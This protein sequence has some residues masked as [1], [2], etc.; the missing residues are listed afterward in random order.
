MFGLDGDFESGLRGEF[1]F[2]VMIC[3]GDDELTEMM[4][5]NRRVL[6]ILQ[7]SV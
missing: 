2:C 4:I 7:H 6:G 5:I 1:C 3:G